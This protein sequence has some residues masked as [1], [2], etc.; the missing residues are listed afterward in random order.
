MEGRTECQVGLGSD[1]NMSER[2]EPWERHEVN[3]CDKAEAY[4]LQQKSLSHRYFS[5][6]CESIK[7]KMA[8]VDL[9]AAAW[10]VK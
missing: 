2:P 6:Q 4:D 5:S 8:A 10:S 7:N 9:A 1:Q 3:A